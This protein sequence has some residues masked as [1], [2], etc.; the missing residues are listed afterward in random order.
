MVVKF[1]GEVGE[2]S[3]VDAGGVT[4]RRCRAAALS[5]MCLAHYCSDRRRFEKHTIERSKED[6][7]LIRLIK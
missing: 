1:E 7:D 4:G 2:S 3:V 6:T 5:G